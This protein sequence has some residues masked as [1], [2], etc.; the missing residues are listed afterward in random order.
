MIGCNS[1]DE[2]LEE[3][4]RDYR[5]EL[6]NNLR[7]ARSENASLREEVRLLEAEK[8]R[9]EVEVERLREDSWRERHG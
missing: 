6:E 5:I 3:H 2:E 9:L 1:T 8:E 7:E 4:V